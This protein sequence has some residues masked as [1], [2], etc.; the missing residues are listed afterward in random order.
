MGEDNYRLKEQQVQRA[1]YKYSNIKKSTAKVAK[2]TER[3]GESRA[4]IQTI[5]LIP[6]SYSAVKKKS[7]L[8][9]SNTVLKE[10]ISLST[11]LKVLIIKCD[12][13]RE[14]QI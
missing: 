10:A 9:K 1:I 5:S 8:G 12:N 3:A 4:L 7:I 2:A 13:A 11:S 14:L 6:K